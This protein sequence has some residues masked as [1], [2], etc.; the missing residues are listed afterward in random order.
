MPSPNHLLTTLWIWPTGLFPR[1]LV[2][3]LRAKRITT[4]HLQQ[5]NIHLVPVSLFNNALVSLEGYE[6]RPADTSLPV[7]RI[8][9]LDG[10]ETWIRESS[11]ILEYFEEIFAGDGFLDMRGLSMQQRAKTRDVLSLLADAAAWSSVALM[12]SNPSTTFWSGLRPDQMSPV[13][14][15][16]AERKCEELLSKLER[17]VVEDVIDGRRKSLSGE[18][19][20]VT[21]ADMVVMAQVEYMREMYGMDWVAEH[22][23]LRVWCDR[24]KEEEWVIGREALLEVERTGNWYGVLGA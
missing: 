13:T 17:W 12:H 10:T 21:L 2:Y 15:S 5:H 23:V 24:A 1:R 16:H 22:G 9:Q 14:A 20:D 3:Y 19:G 4:T 8:Q 7:M 18:G 11:T 6:P